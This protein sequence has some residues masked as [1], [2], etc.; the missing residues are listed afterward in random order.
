MG[1]NPSEFGPNGT[2]GDCGAGCPVENVSWY[3]VV[4]YSIVL[5]QSAQLTPCY[6]MSEIVCEDSSSGDTTTWCRD[7]G[8]I[9]AATVSLN[10]VGSVY[11][12]TGYRLPAEA[13]WEY[14]ARA[15]SNTPFYPSTG[16]DGGITYTDRSPLDEN[17]NLI[18]WYGGN[19]SAGYS[20]F[21]CSGWFTGA[22]TCGTQGVGDMAANAYGL[23]DMSGNVWEWVWDPY[24][25]D[26]E[27]DLSI[28]PEAASCGGLDRVLRGGGWNSRA[29]LCR[30]AHRLSRSLGVRDLYVGFRLTRTLP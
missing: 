23:H 18:G 28:D 17:L 13:E 8:G 21:N 25:V 27:S 30:S 26:Y 19:S 14:A 5:S 29:E 22:T 20:S 12:C 15:G 7:H 6:T 4:A 24:C 10:N 2:Y 16:N 3:D 11:D 9:A 1:Y